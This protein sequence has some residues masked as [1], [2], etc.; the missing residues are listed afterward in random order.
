MTGI[1]F[2]KKNF[3]SLVH[4]QKSDSWSPALRRRENAAKEK[5][6]PIYKMMYS[7]PKPV[8]EVEMDSS[9]L[10]HNRTVHRQ[11]IW[12]NTEKQKLY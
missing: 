2:S 4:E 3:G 9:L 6:C 1:D 8:M 10:K 5:I 11:V 7:F 12:S